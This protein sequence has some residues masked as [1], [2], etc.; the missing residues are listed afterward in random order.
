MHPSNRVSLTCPT[1]HKRFRVPAAHASRRVHC[2]RRCYDRAR[3]IAGRKHNHHVH[4]HQHAPGHVLAGRRTQVA[5]LRRLILFRSIGP[6]CHRCRFCRK[7]VC[8]RPNSSNS[9]G[10]LVVCSMNGKAKDVRRR[11]L[12]PACLSCS[13][14]RGW[15]RKRAEIRKR[16]KRCRP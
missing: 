3:T 14:K 16:L 4:L 1:C 12:V 11:N 13:C 8:W 5:L 6:G 2:G 9:P 10:S 15:A 7:R